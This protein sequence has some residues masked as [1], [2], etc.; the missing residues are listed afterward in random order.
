M[1]WETPQLAISNFYAELVCHIANLLRSDFELLGYLEGY[2]ARELAVNQS[3]FYFFFQR[4]VH[5]STP[6]KYMPSHI[7]TRCLGS[8]LL[9][10]DNRFSE[11]YRLGQAK[12]VPLSSEK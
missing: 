2:S 8:E 5:M 4:P 10:K 3:C 11:V 9:T 7:L 12:L 6:S 1:L